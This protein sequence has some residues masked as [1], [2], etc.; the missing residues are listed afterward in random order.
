MKKTTAILLIC[1]MISMLTACS[2]SPAEIGSA[3]EPAPQSTSSESS[4]ESVSPDVPAT[5]ETDV[6]YVLGGELTP[7]MKSLSCY[8]YGNRARLKGVLDKLSAGET[9]TVAFL[10]GSITQGTSAG[11]DL[12]YARLTTNRLQE[13]FPDAKIN[14]V[15]AGIGATGS[16]IGVHRADKDVLSKNPDLVFVDF[17]V[18]DTS[19]RT[20]INKIAY[21]SLLRKLWESDSSPAIITIAM[22]QDNGTSF[23][24]QHG[25]IA[26]KLDI[27]MISYKD[28][29]MYVINRGDIK[30][31]DISDDNIHPN[32]AGHALLT[33]II[34]N[35]IEG[36]KNDGVTETEQPLPAPDD[37][38][39]K[40]QNAHFVFSDDITPISSGSFEIIA[41][42]MGGFSN[43]WV[44]KKSDGSF[45]DADAIEFEV[46]A[47]N[48][49]V[50]YGK[51][52]KNF[53]K[54]DVYIDGELRAT[55]DAGF[56][57][58][59]GNYAEFAEIASFSEE[60]THRVR[61]VPQAKDGAA[62]FYIC[63]LALS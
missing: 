39:A 53:T 36:A 13:M 34:M 56:A 50:L 27:P 17:S 61:I 30:W 32:V 49:G 29:V 6:P 21:E 8:N 18:N 45:T 44:A 48:I 38:V 9:V 54:A 60:G 5:D 10:G 4:T 26:K 15:N 42:G 23:Q 33:D 35:Y 51:L 1:A 55:I 57:G 37:N 16:Y 41:G 19:D 22:T 31:T 11:S 52:I 59:W 43:A 46:T 3:A 40:Y 62:A 28:A 63:G 24:T 2:N 58:G 47:R 20:E 25:E 7:S 14:Y 12:C